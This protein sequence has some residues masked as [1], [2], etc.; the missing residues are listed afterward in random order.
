[1]AFRHDVATR[2]SLPKLPL[3]SLGLILTVAD[4][5]ARTLKH[6]LQ[7]RAVVAQVAKR[8]IGVCGLVAD[9]LVQRDPVGV[10]VTA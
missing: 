5:I 9:G 4:A 7:Q 10:L 2:W 8:M 3:M 1:M 6:V